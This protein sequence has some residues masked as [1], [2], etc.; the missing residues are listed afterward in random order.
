MGVREY[1]KK[2]RTLTAAKRLIADMVPIKVVA[3]DL[4]YRDA[5][6]FTR[7]FKKQRLTLPTKFRKIAP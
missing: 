2:Q 4:G 5:S 7:F 3:T 1:V 6:H